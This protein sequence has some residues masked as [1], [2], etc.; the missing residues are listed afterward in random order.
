MSWRFGSRANTIAEIPLIYPQSLWM[1]GF[2]IFSFVIFLML[3]RTL[4]A[5]FKNEHAVVKNLIG[6]KSE[7]E[8]IEDEKEFKSSNKKQANNIN[9]E[10]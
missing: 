8:E 10:K 7:K 6:I 4:I 5:F 2:V 1:I 9:Y 3:L